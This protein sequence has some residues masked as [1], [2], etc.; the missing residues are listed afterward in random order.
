MNNWLPIKMN[1]QRLLSLFL[2]LAM[3][4]PAFAADIEELDSI[5][6]VVDDDVITRSELDA[7]LDTLIDQ[8]RQKGQQLP[9]MDVLQRQMLDR[10]ILETLQLAQAKQIGIKV[11]DEDL[12]RIIERIAKS[13]NLSLLQF[14][15]AL[16]GEGIEFANFREEIRNEVTITRLR[17]NQVI[18]RIN[19]SPQE[20]DNLVESMRRNK[21]ENEELHLQHILIALPSDSSPEQ[22][23]QGQ[24]KVAQLLAELK[25][26]AD[27][28]NLA[29]SY[30]AGPQALEGGDLGWRR[31][32]QLPVDF[33]EAIKELGAGEV[34]APIRSAS[35]FHL[36]RVADKRGADRNIIRQ[37]N[38]R[39]IL[40][41]TSALVSDSE[42]QQRLARLRERILGGEEFGTLAKAHSEDTGSAVK[43]GE[44]GWANPAIYVE[45]F[46]E[47]IN[48][49]QIGE[50]SAPFK[51]QFGWHILQVQAWRDYDNTAERERTQAAEA[52]QERKTEVDSAAWRRRLRDEAYIEVRLD[53]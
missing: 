31:L 41:R 40:I 48:N 36:I 7:R 22:V 35:G 6:A 38:A 53:Q 1:K 23:E 19:I 4:L 50:I 43:G 5:V 33:A 27:F 20:I 18:K 15:E 47:T 21:T 28:G 29:I 11:D 30:S 12:N 42:A 14:R 3:A 2:A 10:M 37:V 45:A 25:A 52:L 51:S 13:N 8:L 39:H 9:P 17:N 32:A 46:K 44:L 49:S 16:A 26:G 34:S 24:R